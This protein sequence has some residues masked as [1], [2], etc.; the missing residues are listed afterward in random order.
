MNDIYEI[1]EKLEEQKSKRDR[2]NGNLD[3]VKKQLKELGYTY[4]TATK[5]IDKLNTEIE[6][7]EEKFEIDL[8]KFNEKYG[9]L[10]E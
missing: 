9:E 6:D 1:K 8:E 7:L 2:L 4:K 3:S 5:A 10:L